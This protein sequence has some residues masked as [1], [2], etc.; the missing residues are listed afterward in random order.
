MRKIL[1]FT[2]TVHRELSVM[3][4]LTELKNSRNY[5]ISVKNFHAILIPI[6]DGLQFWF[7]VPTALHAVAHL[8]ETLHYKLEGCGFDSQ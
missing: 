3:R 6:L 2:T 7:T 4:I 1:I 8:V 5:Q